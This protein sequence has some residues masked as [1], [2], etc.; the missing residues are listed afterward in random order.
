ML[1]SYVRSGEQQAANVWQL[2]SYR[3]YVAGR[4]SSRVAIRLSEQDLQ[5]EPESQSSTIAFQPS[6][7]VN[8]GLEPSAQRFSFAWFKQEVV[9]VSDHQAVTRLRPMLNSGPAAVY[10]KASDQQLI[11]R[12][13]NNHHLPQLSSGWQRFDASAVEL[14]AGF[15]RVVTEQEVVL[16]DEPSPSANRADA[17]GNELPQRDLQVAPGGGQYWI[18][19]PNAAWW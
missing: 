7:L 10:F 6:D 2:P 8:S 4:T 11:N 5:L 16:A 18:E 9:G 3:E 17:A 1:S 13:A 14:L 15:R 19:D 12:Y